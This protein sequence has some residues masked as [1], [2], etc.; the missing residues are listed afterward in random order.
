MH[1]FIF[2]QFL[3]N[4]G[5]SHVTAED[6]KTIKLLYNEATDELFLR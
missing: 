3:H 4:C 6:C 1:M 5:H 2:Y